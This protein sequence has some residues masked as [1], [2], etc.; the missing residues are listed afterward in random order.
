MVTVP[1]LAVS[2]LLYIFVV[3]LDHLF[4]VA[5]RL[6]YEAGLGGGFGYS[7]PVQQSLSTHLDGRF[8]RLRGMSVLL[9]SFHLYFSETRKLKNINSFRLPYLSLVQSFCR[10]IGDAEK[11]KLGIDS[12]SPGSS[13]H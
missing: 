5:S 3:L 6:R 2:L 4:N 11:K 13:E 1:F 9:V 12:Q 10:E 7:R 8:G